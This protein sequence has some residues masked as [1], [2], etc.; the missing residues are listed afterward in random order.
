VS[1]PTTVF[2]T[3]ALDHSATL[4]RIL[5]IPQKHNIWKRICKCV[6]MKHMYVEKFE[7]NEQDKRDREL[8]D[9]MSKKEEEVE[10]EASKESSMREAGLKEY[11]KS[12]HISWQA[13]E[14]EINQK[15]KKWYLYVALILVAII[16][17]ALYT[18]SPVMAITFV[19]VG[20][21][22]YIFINKEPRTL[23][24]MITEDG[25]VAGR[26]LYEFDNINSFWIFYEPGGIKVVSLHMKN[27]LMPFVHIPVHDNDPVKI[28]EILLEYV[29]EIKQQPSLVDT[30]E[31]II[32]I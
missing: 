26:D 11:A 24:F 13:P 10:D 32:G 18:D 27:K 29:P 2:K 20:V 21:V 28:R 31:R 4:P 15:E 17:Y 8:A 7:N 16:A 6:S 30:F 12:A 1:F 19:L 14:H 22:G 5:K 9:F 25:V 3:A 23:T